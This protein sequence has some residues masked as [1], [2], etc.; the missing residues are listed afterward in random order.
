MPRWRFKFTGRK[1]GAI[2][3]FYP[4]VAEREGATCDEAALKLY[5]E[6]DHIHACKAQLVPDKP[7]EK[8]P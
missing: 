6:Y 5:D 4:I 8:N 7:K 3:I 2:G 1:K